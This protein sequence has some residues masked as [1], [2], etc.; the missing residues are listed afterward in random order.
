MIY[1][2]Q[3]ATNSKNIFPKCVDC[4]NFIKF[5]SKGKEYD[6]LGACKKNGY[7]LPNTYVTVN[8]YANSCRKYDLYCGQKGLY[9]EKK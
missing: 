7:F 3:F 8:F 4:K 2:R 6:N 5:T 1:I 9:F